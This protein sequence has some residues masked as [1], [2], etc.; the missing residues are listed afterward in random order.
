[1]PRDR[2][3]RSHRGHDAGQEDL[4]EL[5]QLLDHELHS[6][7]EK[8]RLPVV[9]CELEGRS[10]KEVAAQLCLSEGTLSSRLAYAKK[11]LARRLS[12]RGAVLSAGTVALVLAQGA[13]SASLPSSAVT[14]TAK[15]AAGRTLTAGAVSA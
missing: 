2:H 8:Y 5:L 14:T 3:V 13:A 7:P 9:L 6:L 12:R 4:D 15:A 1:V 11:V 10:R